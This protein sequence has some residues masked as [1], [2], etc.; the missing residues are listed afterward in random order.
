MMRET[1][2][3]S[4][5]PPPPLRA[6]STSQRAAAV[7]PKGWSEDPAIARNAIWRRS[8]ATRPGKGPATTACTEG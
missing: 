2:P 3:S 6:E 1:P 5:N 8:G 4:L 7:G